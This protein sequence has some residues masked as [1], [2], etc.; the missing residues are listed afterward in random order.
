MLPLSFWLLCCNNL[1][2]HYH[3]CMHACMHPLYL[4]INHI[5]VWICLPL[6]HCHPLWWPDPPSAMAVRAASLMPACKQR[7]ATSRPQIS[8][9]VHSVGCQC[10]Q[11]A[12][13]HW[14]HSQSSESCHLSCGDW[15]NSQGKTTAVNRVIPT[16]RKKIPCESIEARPMVVVVVVGGT[17]THL[18]RVLFTVDPSVN[19]HLDS[20]TAER[21]I[22]SEMS[23]F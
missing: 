13:D 11:T 19:H 17:S 20:Q 7:R 12:T 10:A 8:K 14:N 23:V 5:N 2:S 9:S 15:K 16:P 22:H 21:H 1:R 18:H 3:L 4:L 6:I